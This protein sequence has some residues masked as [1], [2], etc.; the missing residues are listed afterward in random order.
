MN[1]DVELDAR[2]LPDPAQCRAIADFARN[3]QRAIESPLKTVVREVAP[4]EAEQR[5]TQN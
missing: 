5:D 3:I 2:E 1:D 4:L